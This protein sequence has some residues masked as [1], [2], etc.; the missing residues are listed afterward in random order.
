[1]IQEGLQVYRFTGLLV[2]R[3]TG[4][5]VYRFTGLQVYRFL[6]PLTPP[7]EAVARF[8]DKAKIES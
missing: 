5:Q 4:L 2:Y 8:G 3:F 1:M 6:D 7:F